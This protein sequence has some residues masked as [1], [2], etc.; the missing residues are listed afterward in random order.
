MSSYKYPATNPEAHDE[1]VVDNK[2]NIDETMETMGFMNEYLKEQ[3]QEMRQNAAKANKARKATIL[4]DADVA[5]RIRLAQWEQTCEM[6]AQ[7]AAM[8]AENGRLSEAYSQR[9]RHKARK[10]RKGTTKICIYCYKRHFENDECRRHL[11]L[12]EYPVLF[13]H[14][15]HDGR[16][17]KSHVDAP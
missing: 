14:L 12:D 5:E 3:I 10:F 13:P 16:T 8:A 6:A 4:A 15:D 7:A 17:A 9:N 11:V 2:A 1:A